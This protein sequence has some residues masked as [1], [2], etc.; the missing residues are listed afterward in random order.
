MWYLCFPSPDTHSPSVNVEAIWSHLTDTAVAL[1]FET[2][3][4]RLGLSRTIHYV[5]RHINT[6]ISAAPS[7]SR[8][9]CP[10]TAYNQPAKNS[11]SLL[12]W[13][14]ISHKGRQEPEHM[15]DHSAIHWAGWDGENPPETNTHFGLYSSSSVQYWRHNIWERCTE[16]RTPCLSLLIWTQWLVIQNA[17][18]AQCLLLFNHIV[19][20]RYHFSQWG[21][22]V[23]DRPECVLAWGSVCV[24]LWGLGACPALQALTIL[25]VSTC[26]SPL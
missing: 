7:V 18:L 3:R 11:P 6:L 20:T 21:S 5:G 12:A 13:R 1:V 19:V 25:K 16:W 4:T 22:L 10:I 24:D 9:R 23:Q 14:K 15:Q 17:C 2:G 8:T 26:S